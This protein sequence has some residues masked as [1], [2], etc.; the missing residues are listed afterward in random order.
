MGGCVNWETNTDL[1]AQSITVTSSTTG[2][3]GAK[4]VLLHL[5]LSSE[6]AGLAPG[7]GLAIRFSSEEALQL[8]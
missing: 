5:D 6:Q 7:L 2:P 4:S 1:S 3:A 8:T